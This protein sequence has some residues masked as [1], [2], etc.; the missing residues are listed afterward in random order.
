MDV[1][2]VRHAVAHERNAARWPDD[3]LRPLTGAGKRKFRKAAH[4]LGNCIPKSARVLTSPFVRARETA[5]ILVGAVGCR[6]PIDARELASGAATAKVFSLLRAHRRHA[7]VLVGHE[8][9]LS[10]WLSAAL[11]GEQTR[12]DIEFRKGGAACVRFDRAI[13]PG[14]A[15]LVWMLPPR[16][17]RS[18]R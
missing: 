16:L 14:R 10:A 7:I 17:L 1:Y 4:G 12:L 18:I 8:P 6:K 2:L 15:T 5:D 11:G 9:N 13:T 3:A